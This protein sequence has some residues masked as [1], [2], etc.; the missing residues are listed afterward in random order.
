MIKGELEYKKKADQL[1]NLTQGET[2]AFVEA[3]LEAIKKSEEIIEHLTRGQGK[4]YTHC[5]SKHQKILKAQGELELLEAEWFRRSRRN[6]DL[7]IGIL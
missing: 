7:K 2:L 5:Q 6:K 4:A 3:Q 1:K